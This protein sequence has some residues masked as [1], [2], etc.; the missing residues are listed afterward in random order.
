LLELLD[1]PWFW[2][3]A[4]VVVVVPLLLVVLT[5]V[6]ASLVRRGSPGATIVALVRNYL[7]PVGG[8]LL[9]LS[10]T[11]QVSSPEFTWTRVAATI[12]GFLVIV[13]LLNGLNLAFFVTAKSGT[14]RNRLPSIFTD[15]ARAVLIIVCLAVLFSWVWGADIGG[16]FTALGVGS[17]VIGFALQ[18]AVGS[19]VSGL[20]LLFEHPFQVGDYLRT[21][22]GKGKVVE[23]NWRAVHLDMANGIRVIPNSELASSSFD[24][25][26]R[27][28]SPYE[29]STVVRFTTDD[30]PQA[31]LDLLVQVARDLPKRHPDSEPYAVALDKAKYEINIPLLTPAAEYGTVGLFRSRLWYAARRADLHLDRDVTDNFRT[32]D[33]LLDALRLFAPALYISRDEAEALADRVRL[34]RYGEGEVVQRVATVPDGMRFILSGTVALAAPVSTG[35]ELPVSQLGRKDVLGLA[36][37]T[38]QTVAVSATAASDL[39]VLFVP[40]A[41]LDTLVKTRPALARDIGVEIDNRRVRAVAALQRAGLDEPLDS[42]ILG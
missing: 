18:S 42:L 38:R 21:S 1:E 25:L 22:Q 4:I 31:V 40:V 10:Q 36:A 3:A 8:L 33:R 28:S 13:V 16:L 35:G 26:T 15:I 20:F 17:I 14:W 30:P 12:F 34:E 27:A 23:I 24:N 7:M 32:R 19:V 5:E 41:V 2:P 29:A 39:A 9:L 11:A 37:L 6:H